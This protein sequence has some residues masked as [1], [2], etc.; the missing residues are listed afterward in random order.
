M[1]KAEYGHKLL[2]GD[3][4]EVTER[5]GTSVRYPVHRV[6]TR[7]AFVMWS[8]TGEGKFPRIY[9]HGFHHYPKE[10]YNTSNYTIK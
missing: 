1:D 9:N 8:E 10:K 2:I 3:I 7:Y 6:T 4:I 5:W